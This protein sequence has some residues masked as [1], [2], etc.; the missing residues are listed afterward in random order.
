MAT[1][2]NPDDDEST[3]GAVL[4]LLFSIIYAAGL[5]LACAGGYWLA[6]LGG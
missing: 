2:H 1:I 4:W 5:A 6:G 3:G